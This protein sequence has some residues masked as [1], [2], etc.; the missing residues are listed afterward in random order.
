MSTHYA[1]LLQIHNTA[2]L[3]VHDDDDH[4]IH[5]L[6]H[7]LLITY[8]PELRSRGV[9]FT[10]HK[11][12]ARFLRNS[13][14][15]QGGRFLHSFSCWSQ[16]VSFLRIYIG[17]LIFKFHSFSRLYRLPAKSLRPLIYPNGHW[18]FLND[19]HPSTVFYVL[20]VVVYCGHDHHKLRVS[21]TFTARSS[22]T[23]LD[24]IYL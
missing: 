24:R 22:V 9:P 19:L 6:L 8:L 1:R 18:F 14:T 12:L 13:P 4:Q 15:H 17:D 20:V 5:H 10:T 16:L 11:K 23:V 21:I 7:T 3:Q 2:F